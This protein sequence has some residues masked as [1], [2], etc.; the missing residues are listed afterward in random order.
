MEMKK[1][2]LVIT[3][4]VSSLKKLKCDQIWLIARAGKEIPGTLRVREL[5]PSKQL[6]QRYINEWRFKDPEEW[7]HLYR[8]QFYNELNKEEKLKPLRYLWKL[9]KSGETIALVCFCRDYRYC[10]RS[11]VGD[12]L[13]NAGLVV[14]E[15]SSKESSSIS[16]YE[17]ISLF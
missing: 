1:E 2:G 11:L 9:V 13:R 17:Q 4:N 6:F 16:K 12:F 5:A 8:E 15:F 7:W 10:H 3:T 14:K